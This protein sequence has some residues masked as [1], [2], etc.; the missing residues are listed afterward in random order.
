MALRFRRSVKL[1]PGVRVNLGLRGP[2]ISLGPRGVGVTMGPAGVTTHVGAPGTGLSYRH[3]VTPGSGR[4]LPTSLLPSSA[5]SVGGGQY[6]VG[7]RLDLDEHGRLT[8]ASPEGAA[9][10]P[11]F[12]RHV[13]VQKREALEAWLRERC[14]EI[15]AEVASVTGV[16]LTTPPPDTPHHF[17]APAFTEAP[18]DEPP[19]L[20]V[21]WFDRLFKSRRLRREDEHAQAMAGY[22]A[23]RAA[24]QTRRAAHAEECEG[25]RQR[26]EEQR[27]TSAD[28][29]HDL[30][31]DALAAIDWPRETSVSFEISPEATRAHLDVELAWLEQMPARTAELAARS[32]KLNY[33]DLPPARVRAEYVTHV[34]GVVFRLVGEV[35]AQLPH[36]REVICS[37]H[38]ERPDPATG[39]PAATCLISVRVPRESWAA[40]DFTH[41]A[42]IDPVACLERFECRTARSLSDVLVAVTPIDGP[43][44]A[45]AR[46]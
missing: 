14:A 43:G 39:H 7:L 9:L 23:Q 26:F 21:N 6:S 24:W 11:R 13:R 22:E 17:V 37:G 5:R 15:D 30:L 38:V 40:I 29:M 19:A 44:S 10:D 36:V 16:H 12:E 20:H 33:H 4:A 1:M 31:A 25:A 18:P 46:P 42:A 2:S 32:L 35:F 45:T 8:L 34:H 27:L 41:L 28:V 3:T